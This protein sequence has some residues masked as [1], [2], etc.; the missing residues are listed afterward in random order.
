M[1]NTVGSL[2]QFQESVII[3]TIL[4]DGYLRIVPGR[5]DAL[6]EVNHAFSAK[7]YVD[8]KFQVLK[9]ICISPPKK[10]K[11]N[12]KRIAYRFNTRQHPQLTRIYREFYRKGK[13]IIPDNLKL[14][15]VILSV[16]FMDDGSRCGTSSF[17][18]NTQHFLKKD[19]GKLLK[20]LE[21]LG[22]CGR[23][24]KDKSYYR[25]R[26]LSSSIPRLQN[27]LENNIIP[28]MHYKLGYNPVET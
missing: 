1:D 18:L 21:V 13:K 6:L 10:R 27:L 22:L 3:G 2:T 9:N 20:K 24:N 4:E 12:G 5:K 17:Y 25:I 7:D 28:S 15:E 16:W 11:G 19:Q 23:L 26:F 8:W 14:N